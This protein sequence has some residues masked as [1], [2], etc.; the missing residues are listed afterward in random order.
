MHFFVHASAPALAPLTPHFES[1]TQ[2]FTVLASPANTTDAVSRINAQ[3]SISKTNFLMTSSSDSSP[4]N[5]I[6]STLSQDRKDCRCLEPN[7]LTIRECRL[8]GEG[9]FVG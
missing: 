7:S 3:A 4:H 9:G 2:P 6:S 5:S 1:A 8:S